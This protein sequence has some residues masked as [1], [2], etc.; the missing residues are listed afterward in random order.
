MRYKSYWLERMS[1]F[2]QSSCNQQEISLI[3]EIYKYTKCKKIC[4]T[5]CAENRRLVQV[6]LFRSNRLFERKVFISKLSALKS[7]QKM[8]FSDK[9]PKNDTADPRWNHESKDCKKTSVLRSGTAFMDLTCCVLIIVMLSDDDL[10]DSSSI[11]VLSTLY[12]D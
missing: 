6:L 4:D 1:S 11:N 5:L 8:I 7:A 3:F 12:F 10:T 9:F 2:T